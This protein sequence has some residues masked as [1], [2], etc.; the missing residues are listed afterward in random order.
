MTKRPADTELKESRFI[1]LWKRCTRASSNARGAEIYRE[2]RKR[3]LED[4]RQYHTTAH[5]AHCLKLFDL[6]RDEM[7]DPDA[8]EMSIW[9]H[10]VIYDASA[11]DNEEKSAKFFLDTCGKDADPRFR[12]KVH[13]LII[14][15]IHKE[16]P[17][18]KDEKFM[19]DI[20]LSSF[21]LP[22]DK[23]LKDSEAVRAEFQHMNDE[24]FYPTQ[25]KFLESLVARK[26][27]CFTEFFRTR[28][29]ENARKNIARYLDMLEKQGLV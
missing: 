28:H 24:E 9:F 7:D 8:V 5:I 17:L 25:K 2:L 11:S 19:V 10:D 26:Y 16:L 14:V 15:T 22:W 29:E 27:F 21:G 23:F 6:A 20:D 18:T 13:D 3:Y 4:H 12:A 1:S